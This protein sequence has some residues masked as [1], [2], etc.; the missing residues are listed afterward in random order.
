MKSN[1]YVAPVSADSSRTR[2]V[3]PTS[4]TKTGGCADLA[5][6]RRIPESLQQR[7]VLYLV[8]HRIPFVTIFC[9]IRDHVRGCFFL[10]DLRSPVHPVRYLPGATT[11]VLLTG[12]TSIFLTILRRPSL[13]PSLFP[14]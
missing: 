10:S 13:A 6:R 12:N 4:T 14:R 2:E 1:T 3:W 7:A 11:R 9:A 8:R 5:V